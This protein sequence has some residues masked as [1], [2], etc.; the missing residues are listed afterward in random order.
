MAYEYKIVD[1]NPD[2]LNE[3]G[4]EYWEAVGSVNQN[5]VDQILLRRDTS[6]G[7]VRDGLW[8]HPDGVPIFTVVISPVDHMEIDLA[9]C[10]DHVSR[11]SIGM[12]AISCSN[13]IRSDFFHDGLCDEHFAVAGDGR[14]EYSRLM[15]LC[16]EDIVPLEWCAQLA[17][18]VFKM[19]SELLTM[20]GYQEDVRAT[21]TLSGIKGKKISTMNTFY[22]QARI[23]IPFVQVCIQ[24]S[25]NDLFVDGRTPLLARL[26]TELYWSLGMRSNLAFDEEGKLRR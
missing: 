18:K 23:D 24:A 2:R 12:N 15:T 26:F 25:L 22:R 4:Q 6:I 16:M 9:A 5:G 1:V 11:Q 7:A 19:A 14:F 8:D 3:Y 17:V 21:L 13:G 10:F 20:F